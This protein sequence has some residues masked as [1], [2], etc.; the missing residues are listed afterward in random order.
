M[1]HSS[2][3]VPQV[4]GKTVDS[5]LQQLLDFVVRDY[6]LFYLKDYAYEM[7]NLGINIK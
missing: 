2:G 3:P 4:F 5:L 6:I 7:D 1:K